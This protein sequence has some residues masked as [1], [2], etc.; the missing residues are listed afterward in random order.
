[1][2]DVT[3]RILTEIRDFP[4]VAALTNR[5]RSPEPMGK[6]VDA[7]GA[8]IDEGDGRGAGK[9]V[10]FVVL[11]RLGHSRLKRAPV[12]DVRIL[13][14]CYAATAQ[15]ATALAGAVSDAIHARGHRISASGVAIFGSFDDGGL[16]AEKDPDT[17]QPMESLII[18]VGALTELLPIA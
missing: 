15:G 1:M 10:Q 2:I 13:A 8:V 18:Q 5:I 6:T 3:G 9:Y 4:A 12:Q 14:K 17:G 7:A 16:G 11:T